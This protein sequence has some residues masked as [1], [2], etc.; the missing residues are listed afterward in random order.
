MLAEALRHRLNTNGR[1]IVAIDSSDHYEFRRLNKL[2]APHVAGIKFT[3]LIDLYGTQILSQVKGSLLKFADVK[4]NDIPN[5]VV[6]RLRA[7]VHSA[8]IV[9]VHAGMP[10][11]S[12][13]EAG[14][15]GRENNIAV[16]AVTALTAFTPLECAEVYGRSLTNVMSDFILRAR[17]A[18]LAGIVCS[19]REAREVKKEWPNA[20]VICQGIRSN[21]TD[22]DDQHRSATP[23]EAIR[24]GA[25]ILVVSRPITN[26]P[27]PIAITKEI[28]REI[29]S[30]LFEKGT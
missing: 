22:V 9:T 17:L 21:G 7:Y 15:L 18:G 3:N 6:D 4:L 24:N 30:A 29:T 27:D 26:A 19:A 13:R 28:N 14:R 8:E 5:T 12:L 25:D 11:E 23:R 20:L 16:V 10:L 1:V 2:L